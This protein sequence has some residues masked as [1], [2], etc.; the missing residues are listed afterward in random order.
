M[1]KI[2]FSS[3]TMLIISLGYAQVTNNGLPMLIQSGLTVAVEGD[4]TSTGDVTNE[5]TMALRNAVTISGNYGGTGTLLLDG[6]NQSLTITPKIT[7][8]LMATGGDKTLLSNLTVDDLNLTLSANMIT[9]SN[10]LQV[11]GEIIGYDETFNIEGKLIRTGADS[12]YYPISNGTNYTPVSLTGILGTSPAIGVQSFE[13]AA[14]GSTGYGL[15]A[16]NGDRYW[17]ISQDGGTFTS[18][19]VELPVINE[20]IATTINELAVAKLS[21]DAFT[22]LG[23]A[24]P[25][26]DL[27]A[28]TIKA[29]QASGIG[30]YTVGKYFDEALRVNDSLAL[31]SIY[32]NL[33]GIDWV[34]KS[35]WLKTGLDNWHGVS[36]V[37]KRVS[38]IGLPSNNLVGE[39]PEISSGLEDMAVLNLS[40]N[41]IDSLPALA[42]FGAITAAQFANNRLDFASII[43]NLG[44]SGFDY[45][46][47]KEVGELVD[48]LFEQDLVQIYTI[49]R[50][51]GGGAGNSYSWF[52]RDKAGTVTSV[53]NTGPT[54]DLSI[55][56]FDDEGYYYT[57][58]TNGSVPGLTLTTY[59]FFV[60]VSS[61]SRDSVALMELYNAT[62]GPNWINSS[63]WGSGQVSNNWFGVAVANNRV[64]GVSLPSNNMDGNV[65]D[66]FA[67]LVS[68][69]AVNVE[70]NSLRSFPDMTGIPTLTSLDI[71]DNRLVFNDIVP[72]VGIS[73]IDYSNQKRFGVTVYDTLA[74]GTDY[75]LRYEALGDENTQYQWKFAPLLPGEPY[76]NDVDTIVGANLRAYTIEN[77]D[78]NNQG[79][80]RLVVSH[81]QAPG[82]VIQSRN[83]NIMA[84]TDFI[85]N[86]LFAGGAPLTN[87]EVVV[88]R[89]TPQG[90]FQQENITTVSSDGSYLLEEVVLGTFLV[91]ARP[92][93]SLYPDAIQTYY[94]KQQTYTDADTLQLE[95]VTSGIDIELIEITPDPPVATGARIYGYVESE[96][97]DPIDEEGNRTEAR[98]KV[99]KA[100]CSM[101]RFKSQGRPVQDFQDSVEAEIAYYIETDD[102]G[103]FNFEGVADGKYLISIEFPG[104]PID[105][106]SEVVFE[107][108]GDKENQVIEVNALITELGIEVDQTEI[109][110]TLKPYIKDLHF[111]PNP[112]EGVLALDYTVYRSI[113]DLQLKLTSMDGRII[114]EAEAPHY[115]GRWH[116]QLDLSDV[117]VG[118]YHLVFTDDAGTF[119]QSVKVGRN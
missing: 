72:N 22:G 108:G 78:I 54:L 43:P 9:G 62:G 24:T 26:G 76:N 45:N 107:V 116:T 12:L 31:V 38:A 88:W 65:P 5:G 85:G 2:I 95:G 68:L 77:I 57:E 58:V 100:A 18:A 29:P 41:E 14:S 118:I 64:T 91:V 80:Y 99:R 16:V 11:D 112:T 20:T 10:A 39:Y 4:F 66:G 105:P 35:G 34:N 74:A 73:N 25:T 101:R 115:K 56:S 103:Y 30:T 51:I 102:E 113:E 47:Q 59:D 17:Q 90:P 89:K 7:T 84:Q 69:T 119:R 60:K 19:F 96:F 49:S 48:T 86:V 117:S 111:Y 93:R 33:I 106:T 79:T 92:D 3:F 23:L 83:Q 97:D 21:G 114:K 40:D 6:T 13:T 28:G 55:Q 42:R 61:L 37:D 50:A 75:E 53:P 71:S 87:G 82:L 8:L 70:N 110:Y 44:V 67:D 15:L 81:P 27:T 94:V 1:K 63:G 109:L 36:M 46:P 32:E 98:R 104:V 52:K